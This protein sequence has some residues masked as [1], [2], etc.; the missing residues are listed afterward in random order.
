VENFGFDINAQDDEGR[1]LL[2]RLVVENGGA[3]KRI[4]A[5]WERSRAFGITLQKKVVENVLEC[6]QAFLRLGADPS[7]QDCH[8]RLVRDYVN[9]GIERGWAWGYE[10]I[11]KELDAYRQSE[12]QVGPRH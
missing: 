1:T 6:I 7:I 5:R 3:T 12:I 11:L 10:G 2:H 4:A 8:G 9:L